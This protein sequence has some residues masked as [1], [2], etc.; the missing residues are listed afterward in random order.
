MI[1]SLG[2]LELRLDPSRDGPLGGGGVTDEG[3]LPRWDEIGEKASCGW[4]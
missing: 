2:M 3:G 1:R 4:G